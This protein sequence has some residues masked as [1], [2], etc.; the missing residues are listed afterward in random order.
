VL[1]LQ[2][3]Y[4]LNHQ[5]LLVHL[6]HHLI[7]HLNLVNFLLHHLHHQLM[8]LFLK[9]NYYQLFQEWHPKHYNLQILLLHLHP[10]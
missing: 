6:H 9:L 8:L 5:H 7:L 10:L 2:E 3:V 1:D 4:Y